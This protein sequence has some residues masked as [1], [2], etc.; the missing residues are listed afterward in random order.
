MRALPKFERMCINN[1]CKQKKKTLVD[2]T[3]CEFLRKIFV[4]AKSSRNI[5]L[6]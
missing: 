3:A 2:E 1:N 4:I 5:V 6:R